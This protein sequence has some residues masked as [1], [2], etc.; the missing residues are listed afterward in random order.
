MKDLFIV[1]DLHL[2]PEPIEHPGRESFIEFLSFL[3]NRTESGELWILGDLFDFWFEYR[4]VVPAGYSR[5][6]AS[7]RTL[8]SIGWDVHFL[9]GNHDFWVGRHFRTATGAIVHSEQIVEVDLNGRPSALAHGDGLGRGDLGYRLIKPFLRCGL[10]RILFG[11]LHPD[12][13]A[14]LAKAFSGTSRRVLRREAD[15]IPSGLANWV[16]DRLSSGTEIVVTGHTHVDSII[17]RNTGLHVSLGDWLVRMTYC[18]I[19]GDGGEPVLET[20]T[21]CPMVMAQ[22]NGEQGEGSAGDE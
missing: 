20:W 8:S 15:S 14:F 10:S 9:P 16:D 7:L 19:P 22:K 5:V 1:S 3:S 4:S 2:H 17:R 6:L 21:G 12:L 13:G 11:L 18:I